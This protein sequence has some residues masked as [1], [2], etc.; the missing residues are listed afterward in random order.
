MYSLLEN[1]L[2]GINNFLK[3]K[4]MKFN[5]FILLPF[6][7]SIAIWVLLLW[8]LGWWGAIISVLTTGIII[9][10]ISYYQFKKEKK[11]ESKN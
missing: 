10:I 11:N 9:S 3:Y 6:I 4:N 5:F 7:F 2:S 8:L 1:Y